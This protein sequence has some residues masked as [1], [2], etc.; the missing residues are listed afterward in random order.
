MLNRFRVFMTGRNGT[1]TL[2]IFLF[3]SALGMQLISGIT[4]WEVF[5]LLGTIALVL[6]LYRMFS[7]NLA[8]R[9]E[10]N[11]R[12]TQFLGG[13]QSRFSDWRARREQSKEY[14]FFTCP[15]CKNKLR[16]PRG[17]GK[18]QVTCPRCGERFNGHT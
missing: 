13:S 16:V 3:F 2:N 8:R 1:D 7:R 14:K 12:F 4:G 10:E 11:Y 6:V 17:K 15:S 9:Q 5:S 18:I